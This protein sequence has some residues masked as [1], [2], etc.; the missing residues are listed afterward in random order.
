MDVRHLLLAVVVLTHSLTTLVWWTA[1]TWLGL[2]SKA[3]RHWLLTSLAN[4]LALALF[5]LNEDQK[6]LAQ[7]LLASTLVLHG[8]I[9]LRRGLQSFLKLQHTDGSHLLV[10]LGSTVLCLGLCLPMGWRTAGLVISSLAICG[11]FWRTV[12][13]CFEPLQ[14]E[15]PKG[16]AWILSGLLSLVGLLF[17]GLIA[18]ELMPSIH[19]SWLQIPKDQRLSGLTFVSVTASILST[20]LLGYIVLTRLVHRLEHLSHHDALTGLL[21]RRAIEYLMEREAQRLHRFGEP[22]SVLMVDIDY[23]KRINDRLGHAA[24]DAVLCAVAQT[25]QT[26]AREIDRAA[27]FGGEE[28]CVLLPH[29]LHDGALLAAERLRHA[30]SQINVPWG[31]EK[32]TVTISTG[33]ATANDSHETLSSLLSRCDDALYQAKREGRNKVVSAPP[34]ARQSP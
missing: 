29:T 25:L 10:G 15:Y 3:A 5:V 9:S 31:D 2:S 6:N 21:N 1:G 19:W 4:G 23:F 17:A 18:S 12:R 7:L 14:T 20:F 16:V 26:Q 24:G 8:A 34:P 28:F 33:L 13:E 22:F 11:V 27:R 32:V 30:I